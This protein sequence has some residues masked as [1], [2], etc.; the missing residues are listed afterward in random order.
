[1]SQDTQTTLCTNDRAIKEAYDFCISQ[2]IKRPKAVVEV[3]KKL[4]YNHFSEYA[5]V[6]RV[7]NNYKRVHNE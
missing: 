4:G 1:M 3:C 5:N 2:G 7:C 6:Y